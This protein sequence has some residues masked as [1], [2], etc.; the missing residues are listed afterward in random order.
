MMKRDPHTGLLEGN[1]RKLGKGRLKKCQG[2]KPKRII[3]K[4]LGIRKIL[5]FSVVILEVR[6][7]GIYVFK[8]ENYCQP[9]IL[10]FAKIESNV[11]IECSHLSDKQALKKIYLPFIYPQEVIGDV[12]TRTRK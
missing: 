10:Y 2:Q 5:D 12:S 9:R 6:R 7:S 4:V 3:H 1:I 11:W 8:T